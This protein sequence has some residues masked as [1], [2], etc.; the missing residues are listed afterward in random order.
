MSSLFRDA[1]PTVGQGGSKV[2]DNGTNKKQTNRY[3]YVCFCSAT[4]LTSQ[5]IADIFKKILNLV[6]RIAAINLFQ[7]DLDKP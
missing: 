3:Q 5:I 4:I 2:K 1:G 6:A 7:I